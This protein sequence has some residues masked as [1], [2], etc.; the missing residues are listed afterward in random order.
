MTS[1]LPIKGLLRLAPGVEAFKWIQRVS[2]PLVAANDYI[3]HNLMF[4]CTR[5]AALTKKLVAMFLP[6]TRTLG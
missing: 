4:G 2:G 1:E 6:A 5:V 3:M